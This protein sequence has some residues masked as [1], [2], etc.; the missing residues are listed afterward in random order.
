MLPQS[1]VVGVLHH[2]VAELLEV[3]LLLVEE[4]VLL[5]LEVTEFLKHII[6]AHVVQT[7]YFL[8]GTLE[9]GC[10]RGLQSTIVLDYLTAREVVVDVRLSADSGEGVES[11][12]G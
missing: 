4:R 12:L 8:E 3:E 6:E 2:C 5:L 9:C 7:N 10:S 1:T 11:Y